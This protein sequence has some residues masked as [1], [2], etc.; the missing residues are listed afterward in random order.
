MVAAVADKPGAT[1][2]GIQRLRH[3]DGSDRWVDAIV[4][5]LM[6]DPDGGGIV[7]SSRDITERRK[8]TEALKKAAT[9]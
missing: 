7:I 3:K 4:A 5:Y 1:A 8:V 9:S 6:D 2:T